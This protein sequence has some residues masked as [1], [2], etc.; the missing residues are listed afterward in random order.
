MKEGVNPKDINAPNVTF[1]F[2]Q[3]IEKCKAYERDSDFREKAPVT[4]Q[5]RSGELIAAETLY[6]S[7]YSDDRRMSHPVN[8]NQS[9]IYKNSIISSRDWIAG[10]Q[11]EVTGSV[12]SFVSQFGTRKN[13]E[14]NGL[15]ISILYCTD[16]LILH[17]LTHFTRWDP[18][19]PAF[20]FMEDK[21]HGIVLKR[22]GWAKNQALDLGFTEYEKGKF[23]KQ[24]RE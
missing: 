6:Y 7:G 17:A 20:L 12:V 24:Y 5:L 13:W 16:S 8:L 3:I 4:L 19:I 15:A 2:A 18:S 14:G 10:I 21:S 9:L 22:N 11:S 1:A 23:R